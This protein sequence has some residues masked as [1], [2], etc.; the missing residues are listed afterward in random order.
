MWNG[1]CAA[2][3]NNTWDYPEECWDFQ[4]RIPIGAGAY[5]FD[6]DLKPS[7]QDVATLGYRQRINSQMAAGITFVWRRQKN[8]IDVYDPTFSGDYVVT[9]VPVAGDFQGSPDF[10]EYQAVM[11]DFEKRYSQDRISIMAN[12]TYSFKQKTWSSNWYRDIGDWIFTDPSAMNILWYGRSESPH[13][14]KFFGSYVCPWNMVVGVNF[15]WTSGNVDTPYIA[16]DY[17]TN[18]PLAERGSYEEGS[19]N[20]T[21]L[22]IEQPVTFGGRFTVA[23][24]ANIFNLFNQQQV[25]DR[26]MNS[27]LTTFEDPTAWRTPRAYQFGFKFEF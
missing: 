23:V 1:A 26:Q 13:F 12:Y 21:D 24:Y 2:D 22:Y 10:S 17:P 14:F 16:S 25:T 7:Y 15:T 6:P 20:T 19:Y 8:Q 9:N 3:P 18:T 27:A 4:Y 5:R 11:L